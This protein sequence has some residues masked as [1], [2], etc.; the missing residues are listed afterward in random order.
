MD[1]REFVKIEEKKMP[2]DELRN[3]DF[4]TYKVNQGGFANLLFLF[5]IIATFFMWIM[6]LFLGK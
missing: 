3:I 1:D 5:G 4:D 2:I 6:L